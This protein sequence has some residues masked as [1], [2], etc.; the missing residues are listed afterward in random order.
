MDRLNQQLNW[1]LNEA[2]RCYYCVDAP[3]IKGCPAGIDI[4][5][6]IRCFKSGNIRGAK[7]E[8]KR[9][10][11]LGGICGYL[12]PSEQLCEAR[13]VR[14]KSGEPVK[15]RE[16]Q[17]FICD[18][19]DYFN[20]KS[21]EANGKKAAVI[22]A[23][24]AG[25]SCAV[26]LAQHGFSV[27]VYEK[28][29]GKGGTVLTEIPEF[30]VPNSVIK[31]DLEENDSKN[32]NYFYNQE[33][34]ETSLKENMKQYD[35]VFLSTGLSVEREPGVKYQKSE[36][37]INSAEFLRE[38]KNGEIKSIQGS[39]IVL[40]GG[41]TAIDA[42][43]MAQKLGAESVIIAYRRSKKE[44]P[45]GEEQFIDGMTDGIQILYL[46]TCISIDNGSPMA[47]RF[48][49]NRLV[50]GENGGRSN[51]IPVEGSGFTLYADNIIFAFGKKPLDLIGSLKVNKE[52]L[53]A[54]GTNLYVGGDA[55]NG[56]GTVVEAVRDGKAA[57]D[58]IIRKLC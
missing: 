2:G 35:A 10:N 19:V 24:P 11:Y 49:K 26:K 40:G 32:I 6:F 58:S 44:M 17:K 27:D 37:I 57:A 53:Q 20:H 1:M 7:R 46:T 56:G 13:C 41:D 50:P 25:I 9:A 14:A 43:R 28:E 8:I 38:S 4:P 45:A 18:N 54:E 16:L 3:C 31:R 51:F 52:T 34:D 36:K 47:V 15:I 22:G 23:G 42:A 39:V 55:Y 21:K 5:Q 29:K 30:R 48:I 12:C 33:I